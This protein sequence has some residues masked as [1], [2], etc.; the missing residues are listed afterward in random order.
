MHPNPLAQL[1]DFRD[2]L[3]TG[4]LLEIFVHGP[5]GERSQPCSTPANDVRR[6]GSRP[7]N[8]PLQ[9]LVSRRPPPAHLK[10]HGGCDQHD[11]YDEVAERS[12][13]LQTLVPT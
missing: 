1:R 12:A 11:S 6:S 9:P 8:A 5:S 4:H 13:G 3:L 2:E 10:Q 7:P